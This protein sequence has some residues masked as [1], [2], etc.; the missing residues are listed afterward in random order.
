MGLLQLNSRTNEPKMMSGQDPHQA[1]LIIPP[2]GHVLGHAENAEGRGQGLA[3]IHRCG[4][5]WGRRVKR[6]MPFSSGKMEFV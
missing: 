5:G 3:W 1:P 6:R 2:Y 4:V